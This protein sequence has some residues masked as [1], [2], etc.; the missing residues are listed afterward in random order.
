MDKIKY[1]TK[2]L[3]VY[4]KKVNERFETW[5]FDFLRWFL[6][7]VAYTLLPIAVI[8]TIKAITYNKGNYLYLSPEWSFATI[9][10]LGA[11]ITRLIELKT[12]IQQDSSHK[13]YSGTRFY[14]LLLI[15]SVIVLSLVVLRDDGLTINSTILWIMQLGLLYISLASLYISYLAKRKQFKLETEF[16][17]DMGRGFYFK[18]LNKKLNQIQDEVIYLKFALRKHPTINYPADIPFQ[19]IQFWENIERDTLS[20]RFHQLEQ[21]IAEINTLSIAL[22][23]SPIPETPSSV[24]ANEA[25]DQPNKNA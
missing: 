25:P 10:S 6:A 13:I 20:Q 15:A 5:S 1:K 2:N 3:I 22:I 9:V 16:P 17:L 7:D 23:N 14:I 19:D 11:A 24:K 21:S 18:I 12:K 8:A 4:L